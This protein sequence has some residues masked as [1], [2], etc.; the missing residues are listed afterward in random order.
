V[1]ESVPRG[2]SFMLRLPAADVTVGADAAIRSPADDEDL[3]ASSPAGVPSL[4]ELE[5]ETTGAPR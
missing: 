1:L 4:C 3:R 5:P 2:A